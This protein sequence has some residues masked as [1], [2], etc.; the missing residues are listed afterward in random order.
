MHDVCMYVCMYS[1]D[2]SRLDIDEMPSHVCMEYVHKFFCV[3]FYI[4]NFEF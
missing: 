4:L 3:F 2:R 1:V